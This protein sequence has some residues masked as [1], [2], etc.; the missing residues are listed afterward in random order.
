MAAGGIGD[1]DGG[2][3]LTGTPYT[4]FSKLACACSACKAAKLVF[5]AMAMACA[6]ACL[7]AADAAFAAATAFRPMAPAMV[8]STGIV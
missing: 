8:R 6:A 7:A 2:I 4:Y 3:E 5:C 1:T